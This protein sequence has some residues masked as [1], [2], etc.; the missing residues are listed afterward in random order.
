[1]EISVLH[2]VLFFGKSLANL[3]LE[4]AIRPVSVGVSGCTK[5]LLG[6]IGVVL[7]V[8]LEGGVLLRVE[9]GELEFLNALH[10]LLVLWVWLPID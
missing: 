6:L 9:T 8:T 7:H 4:F 10:F 2:L 3:V 1:M 5:P